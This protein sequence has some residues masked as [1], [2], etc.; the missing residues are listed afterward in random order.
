MTD[1]GAWRETPGELVY[2]ESPE[3]Q[4]SAI[5]TA[6]YELLAA[7]AAAFGM[8]RARSLPA[9]VR[10]TALI[11][12]TGAA[13]LPLAY[14]SGQV[15]ADQPRIVRRPDPFTTRYTFV[16]QTLRALLEDGEAFW[17]LTIPPG[18]TYP[19]SAI[20][21]ANEEVSVQWDAKRFQREYWWRGQKQSAGTIKHVMIGARAG[22]LHGR[23]PLR[24]GLR[25]L[26]PVA[27]AED[28]ALTFFTSGGI[29]E[30]VIKHPGSGNDVVAAD[31]KRRWMESR[32]GPE[33][34]VLFGGIDVQFPGV[35]AE[36]AQLQQSR[37]YGATVVSRLLGIPAA[38]MLVET[39][40]ATITY[41]N[42]EGAMDDL[43]KS[44]LIPQYLAPVEQAWSDLVPLPQ[45]VRFD[46]GELARISLA[47]RLAVY[48]VML[49]LGLVTLEGIAAAEGWTVNQAAG[50]LA[51]AFDPAGPVETKTP[52]GIPA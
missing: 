29:P 31:L 46:A 9:V 38:L 1:T 41:T 15:M 34:A 19:V 21:L 8:E 48:Q 40:G 23:G 44:T 4:L 12:G 37:A 45:T 3:E 18:E 5:T 11:C 24:E 28:Y 39:S 22:E 20:V 13:L 16:F 50:E 10:A 6:L 51:H 2:R 43:V 30:T 7:R 47:A 14:R 32:N 52:E 27:A 26:A 35:D 42:P 49:E 25:Y 17:R 33:P 36:N